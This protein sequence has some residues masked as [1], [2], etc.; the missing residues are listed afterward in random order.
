M[1][2]FRKLAVAGTAA[3]LFALPSSASAVANENA[4]CVG[5]SLSVFNELNPLPSSED[6]AGKRF[7]AY[8]RA[9]QEVPD[10]PSLGDIFRSSNECQGL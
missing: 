8:N 5:Q 9:R 3:A 7:S 2:R 10:A 6:S 4:S 1:N